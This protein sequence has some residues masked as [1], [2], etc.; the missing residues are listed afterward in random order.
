MKDGIF[1]ILLFISIL[2][3][4]SSISS[5]EKGMGGLTAIAAILATGSYIYS[6]R[7]FKQT[8]KTLRMTE[9]EQ[10]IRD[11]EKRLELFYFPMSNYFDIKTG[12]KGKGGLTID[13]N[14]TRIHAESFR[15][16][17]NDTTRKLLETWLE[18]IADPKAT[19]KSDKE[20]LLKNA[21]ET[22]IKNYQIDLAKLQ[23]DKKALLDQMAT[24]SPKEEK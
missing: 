11:I 4:F 6:A 3:C 12:E 7:A 17:A 23:N 13:D 1:A 15:Y 20:G 9:T 5:T 21:I 22:D 2:I 8:E 14:R 18:A 10:Q 16:L 24:G 19:D